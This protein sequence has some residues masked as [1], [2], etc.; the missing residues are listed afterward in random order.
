MIQKTSHL[1]NIPT[2]LNPHQT[3]FLSSIRVTIEM[4]DIAYARLLE[5]LGQ[6]TDVEKVGP[7][8]ERLASEALLD[9]WSI[10]DAIH[11]LRESLDQMLGLVRSRSHGLQ[12]FKRRTADFQILRNSVQHLRGEI[13]DMAEKGQA[14]WGVLSW[15]AANESDLTTLRACSLIVGGQAQ[16]TPV[17]PIP[18]A[19]EMTG[20][21]SRVILTHK[22]LQVELS[23]AVAEVTS[24]TKRL[25]SALEKAWAEDTPTWGGI[26]LVMLEIKPDWDADSSG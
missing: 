24:L 18:V 17:F 11:R 4:V 10:V 13:T 20:P 7:N 16:K 14:A 8:L 12:I 1:K 15:L 2:N 25:E 6:L 22:G 9:A 3:L 19:G 5:T 23:T 21:L 26:R